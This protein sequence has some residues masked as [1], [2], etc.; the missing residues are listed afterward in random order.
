MPIIATSDYV[1]PKILINRHLETIVPGLFRKVKNL[2]KCY[3]MK[4]DTKDGDFLE[5]DR[6]LTASKKVVIISHG[7]EG[8]SERPYILGAVKKFT[9]SNWDVIAWNYRGCGTQMNKTEKFYHSGATYDLDVVVEYAATEHY[10]TIALLGFSLGGNL[11]L[12]YL[13]ESGADLNDKIKATAA[14]SVPF[15]LAGCANEIDKSHNFLY[16]R[17]FL[18]SLR[19]KA[20]EKEKVMPGFMDLS[21]LAEIDSIWEFDDKFTAPLHGFRDAP[22]YY[23]RCSAIHFIDSIKI[24][25]LVVNAANDPFLSPSCLDGT[26]FEPLENVYFEMPKKGG[27]VGFSDYSNSGSY[28][29][30]RRAF[31]FISENC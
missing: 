8:N 2:P 21:K 6:Y 24:P 7:L 18:K 10:E 9:D 14:F 30:D 13:G 17:R 15:D 25:T 23:A 28:W 12:K 20:R 27:H 31:D 16:S 4:I 19:R 22:D 11:T 3:R 5:L 1:K 26:K 29:S